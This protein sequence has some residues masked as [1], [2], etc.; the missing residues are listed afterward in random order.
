MNAK[1]I[2]LPN[3]FTSLTLVS[4]FYSITLA[5]EGAL[6]AAVHALMVAMVFDFLDG[7]VA[8]RTNTVTAFGKEYDS[9]CDMVAFGLAPALTVYQL[10]TWDSLLSWLVPAIYSCAVAMRLARF[11]T[12][13][14]GS[15]S[16]E[17]LP[18]TVGGPFVVLACYFM[19]TYSSV[20]GVLLALIAMGVALLMNS[21][22]PYRSLKQNHRYFRGVIKLILPIVLSVSMLASPLNTLAIVLL[23]YILSPVLGIRRFVQQRRALAQT[24]NSG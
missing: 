20:S 13:E 17:G 16:F 18:C 21:K 5:M 12:K 2:W 1:L 15:V 22:I 23:L 8:R 10:L 14:G 6:D 19:D 9:L 7:W 24:T 4:G 11:N 3:L